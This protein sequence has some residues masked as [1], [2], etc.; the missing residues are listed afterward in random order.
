LAN[1]LNVDAKMGKACARD[2]IV[3]LIAL[4]DAKNYTGVKAI[5][6][7]ARHRVFAGAK[8]ESL[9]FNCNEMIRGAAIRE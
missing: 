1:A 7:T 2:A 8:L 3:S 5:S 9:L 6:T 4:N